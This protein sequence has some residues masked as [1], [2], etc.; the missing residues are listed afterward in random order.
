MTAPRII[1]RVD[2]AGYV[3]DPS[4]GGF[5][6]RTNR[7][8]E[9]TVT[10]DARLHAAQL[11]ITAGMAQ[12][13]PLLVGDGAG[14]VSAQVVAIADASPSTFLQLIPKTPVVGA[15]VRPVSL[16][17]VTAAVQEENVTLSEVTVT[18]PQDD[19]G[20]L[21]PF[22]IT[23][24]VQLSRQLDRQSE[25]RA[26]IA[27]ELDAAGDREEARRLLI[28]AAGDSRIATV[29][30]GAT[31]TGIIAAMASVVG[32]GLVDLRRLVCITG[33]AGLVK[34]G[35]AANGTGDGMVVEQLK[36]LGLPLYVDPGMPEDLGED[37]DQTCILVA[38]A[39]RAFR[40]CWWYAYTLEDI[41][42]L[43]KK[44][45]IERT[46]GRFVRPIVAQPRAVARLQFDVP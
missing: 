3:L 21:P 23:S 6:G 26:S 10:Y 11:A 28:A 46:H 4:F 24:T 39:A 31:R 12:R 1:T 19:N 38:D 22:D 40:R 41:Y 18:T 33:A 14:L 9:E 25:S 36:A 43:K 15:T 20:D 34:L 7:Y 30:G 32:T 13:S 37:E 35:A 27:A 42:T 16:A 17:G 5:V 29:S 2:A 45:M 44:G 8:Q